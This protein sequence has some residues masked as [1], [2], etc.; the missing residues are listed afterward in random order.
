MYSRKDTSPNYNELSKDQTRIGRYV[1]FQKSYNGKFY[2]DPCFQLLK[3][4]DM[5]Q[6]ES[7]QQV[8]LSKKEGEALSAIRNTVIHDAENLVSYLYLKPN[9]AK[10]QQRIRSWRSVIEYMK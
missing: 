7:S 3:I 5:G 9:L 4:N 10:N 2:F 1:W 8:Y 6:F